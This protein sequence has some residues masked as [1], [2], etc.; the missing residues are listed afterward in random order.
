MDEQKICFITSVN[1][2]VRYNES[3][4]YWKR[5]SVPRGMYIETLAIT[6]ASSMVEA[7]QAGMEQSDAKYKI[8]IHQ[9]VWIVGKDFLHTMVNCFRNDENIGM[10]G[11]VG[12]R[13]LPRSLAW[14]EA[15][16]KLGAI[17][18]DHLGNMQPYVYEGN[19]DECQEMAALDGLI[20][21]TQYDLPWR[22]DVFDN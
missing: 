8:Y 17:C 10:A 19:Y 11:V 15:D 9:D 7:Y 5:L 18:D 3:L 21:M 2:I 12:S 14:W 1:D 13:Y 16:D 22:T 20:L 4:E 6:G